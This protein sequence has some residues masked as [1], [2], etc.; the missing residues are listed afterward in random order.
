MQRSTRGSRSGETSVTKVKL[1]PAAALAFWAE[2]EPA[3]V[4]ATVEDCKGK[5]AK[6]DAS[7]IKR[8]NEH[9]IQDPRARESFMVLL[10]K[11]A[12]AG[13]TLKKKGKCAVWTVTATAHWDDGATY[14]MAAAIDVSK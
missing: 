12:P 13:L 11:D 8:P 5:S 7:M 6:V 10:E 3:R 1:Q 9:G 4:E 14:S 2:A